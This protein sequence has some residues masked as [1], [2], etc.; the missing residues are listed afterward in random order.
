MKVFILKVNLDGIQDQPLYQH[1]Q[2]KE[3]SLLNV[4]VQIGYKLA[5][6][7]SIPFFVVLLKMHLLTGLISTHYLFVCLFVF[8]PRLL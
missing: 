5:S 1:P 6:H 3:V 7:N 8:F 4:M 2:A